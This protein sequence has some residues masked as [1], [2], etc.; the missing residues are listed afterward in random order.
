MVLVLHYQTRNRHALYTQARAPMQIAYVCVNH[1]Y[2]Y[3]CTHKIFVPDDVRLL[4]LIERE[5]K[6][7]TTILSTRSGVT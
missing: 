5:L 3:A 6:T 4:G 7:D 1:V 2:V